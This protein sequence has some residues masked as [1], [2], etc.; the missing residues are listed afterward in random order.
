[1]NPWK[2]CVIP[3]FSL[4]SIALALSSCKKDKN[5]NQ[6]LTFVY[7]SQ[8][9]GEIEPCG[10]KYRPLGGFAR[11]KK[12]V[13]QLHQEK[14][15][16]IGLDSGDLFFKSFSASSHEE[17]HWAP[18]AEFMVSIFNDL[19]YV[20]IGLGETDFALGV[21]FLKKLEKKAK[22]SFLNANLVDKTTGRPL[23]IPH[24][25]RSYGNHKIGF[26]SVIDSNLNLPMTVQVLDPIVV[27]QKIVKELRPQVDILIALSHLEFSNDERWVKAVSG[28][29]FVFG[30]HGGERLE[31]PISIG[32]TRIFQA[33]QLGKYVGVLKWEPANRK[34]ASSPE[35]S[36]QNQIVA[37]DEAQFGNGDAHFFN[38]V[39][40]FKTKIA[41]LT[42]NQVALEQKE[43]FHTLEK[44]FSV[45]FST[46]TSCKECHAEQYQIWKSS[47]HATAMV[48]LYI[49]NQHFNPTCVGCHSVGLGKTGG[50]QDISNPFVKADGGKA[51]LETFIQQVMMVK[52][53]E[54]PREVQESLKRDPKVWKHFEAKGLKGLMIELRD[55]PEVDHWLRKRY[56][57]YM[58]KKNWKKNFIG[59]QCENCHGARG[60][61][62]DATQV[63][64]HFAQTQFF[65]K[66]VDKQTCLEC[67][68]SQQDPDFHFGRDRRIKGEQNAQEPF[69]CVLGIFK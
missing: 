56:V 7:T 17:A 22:F 68:T 2:S 55:Y 50:F 29:D 31:A 57:E 3:I 18:Q 12:L 15:L 11:Q 19:N 10:C 64:P 63:V 33:S 44:D 38:Q 49:R 37:L 20:A 47:K 60:L 40:A 46:Y 48:P 21:N 35:S 67:H 61:L 39:Q 4:V 51:S 24:L 42:Q 62:K 65:H 9:L 53:R 13:D 26:F 14:N 54:M 16:V 58:E 1:M 30:G 34:Q 41:E 66:T 6:N 28:I 52:S 43:S 23:F 32:K 69:H 5:L 59:V 8:I 25:I 45:Q 36:Y 27:A